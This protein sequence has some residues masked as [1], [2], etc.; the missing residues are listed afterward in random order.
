MTIPASGTLSL[1]QIQ[2]EMGGSNP[3][4]LSEYYLNGGIVRSSYPDGFPINSGIP[5]SGQISV[6]NFYNGEGVFVHD[7]IISTNTANYNLN[8]VMSAGGWDGIKPVLANVTINSGVTVYSNQRN[9]TSDGTGGTAAFTVGTL[10]ARSTV[11][12]TNNGIIAGGGG[13]GGAYGPT[14]YGDAGHGCPAFVTSFAG[15]TNLINNYRIIGG[16]G[17]G[18]GGSTGPAFG[19]GTAPGTNANFGGGNGGNGGVGCYVTNGYL[20]ITN[21]AILAG[22]GG[23]GPGGN[24]LAWSDCGV[25]NATTNYYLSEAGGGGGGGRGGTNLEGQAAK[26]GSPGGVYYCSAYVRNTYAFYGSDGITDVTLPSP[27]TVGLGAVGGRGSNVAL[28][29]VTFEGG[30]GGFGANSYAGYGSNSNSGSESP[31]VVIPYIEGSRPAPLIPGQGG[32][33]V[34]LGTGGTRGF[35]VVGTIYGDY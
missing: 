24:G 3:I 11:T 30:K 14:P 13:Y 31:Y 5:A 1:S 29:G 22:G 9:G 12:I 26:G 18:G 4:S 28:Y 8:N 16:G 17:G 15:T 35:N 27:I 7:V 33:A 6:S 10:P 19:H 23:G 32:D 20:V 34:T 21:N 25:P 2:T